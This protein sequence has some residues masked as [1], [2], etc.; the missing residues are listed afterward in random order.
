M[1]F[2]KASI[3]SH[4]CENQPNHNG[5]M[6]KQHEIMPKHSQILKTK[7]FIEVQK[8]YKIK[9]QSNKNAPDQ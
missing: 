9:P 5:N 2:S 1:T 4:Y 6:S 7:K 3:L 8:H